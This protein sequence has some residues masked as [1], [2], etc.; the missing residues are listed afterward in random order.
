MTLAACKPKVNEVQGPDVTDIVQYFDDQGNPVT[1][2]NPGSAAASASDNTGNKTSALNPDDKGYVDPDIKV[3]TDYTNKPAVNISIGWSNAS[4]D[5]NK[6]AIGREIQEKFKTT[7]DMRLMPAEKILLLAAQDQL[8]DIFSLGLNSTTFLQLNNEN[9]LYHIDKSQI[10]KYPLLKRYF[11]CHQYLNAVSNMS[12]D[13]KYVGMPF[14]G[15]TYSP[16]VDYEVSL[17]YRKDWAKNVGYDVNIDTVDKAYELMKRFRE[18]DPDGNGFKDTYGFTGGLWAFHYVT[19]VDTEGWVKE[20][21]SQS[22]FYGKYVPGYLNSKMFDAIKWWNRLLKEQIMPADFNLQTGMDKFVANQTGVAYGNSGN[23]WLWEFLVNRFDPAHKAYY[24]T[25]PKID[26]RTPTVQDVVS[27]FP[28]L[29]P[30]ENSNPRFPYKPEGSIR[31]VN[32]KI[33]A[34]KLERLF[35]F[36]EWTMTQEGT[37]YLAYGLRGRDYVV[38]SKGEVVRKLPDSTTTPGAMKKIWEV[39]PSVQ[40]GQLVSWNTGVPSKSKVTDYP[41]WVIDRAKTTQVDKNKWSI[42]PSLAI[43]NI[44]TP[45]KE[46]HMDLFGTLWAEDKLNR[47]IAEEGGKSI[48]QGW[49]DFRKECLDTKEARQIINEVNEQIV[50]KGL[51]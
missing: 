42:T 38:D 2:E 23:Y 4:L 28:P 36:Y 9:Y 22:E 50:A 40:I 5:M 13:K 30:D 10:E 1:G 37:D 21:D 27:E 32:A 35:D 12:A 7:F 8:P 11:G 18:N 34:D 3:T 25:L 26:G 6:D 17:Y 47:I 31:G 51:S 20:E 48:D 43:N 24:P 14:Q 49:Q 46:K 41:P 39:Y 29:K 15:N 33:S 19:W 45:T 16:V 44:T